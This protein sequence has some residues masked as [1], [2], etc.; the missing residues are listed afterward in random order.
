MVW[1]NLPGE[2]RAAAVR[3]RNRLSDKTQLRPNLMNLHPQFG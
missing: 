1:K 3:V 2:A